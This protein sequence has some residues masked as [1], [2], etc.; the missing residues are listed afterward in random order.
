MRT[1][2]FQDVLFDIKWFCVLFFYLFFSKLKIA[3]ESQA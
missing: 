2:I 3:G 1:P